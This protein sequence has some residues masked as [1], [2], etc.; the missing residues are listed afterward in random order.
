MSQFHVHLTDGDITAMVIKAIDVK[1]F[2][3]WP[4]AVEVGVGIGRVI[5][6]REALEPL[7]DGIR[8]VIEG[9]LEIVREHDPGMGGLIHNLERLDRWLQRYPCRGRPVEN[10]EA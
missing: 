6:Q 4:R 1:Q 9:A 5:G 2:G 10:K 7:D 3:A 8:T